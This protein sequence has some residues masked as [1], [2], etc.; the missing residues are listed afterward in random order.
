M[1]RE[2]SK[3]ARRRWRKLMKRGNWRREGRVLAT[4]V[5]PGQSF[6]A[7]CAGYIYEGGSEA[8]EDEDC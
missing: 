3:T 5:A 2:K 1:G 4:T 8:E 7:V 6:P